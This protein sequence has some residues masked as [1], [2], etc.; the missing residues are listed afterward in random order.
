M[1]TDR[2][3]QPAATIEAGLEALAQGDW[4]EARSAFSDVVQVDESPEAL[5]GLGI[6]AWWLEDD[7]AAI[8]ARRRAYRLYQDRGDR[9]GAARVVATGLALDYH[10]RA[11]TPSSTDGS[12]VPTGCLKESNSAPSSDGSPSSKPTSPSGSTTTPPPHKCSVLGPWLS[13]DPLET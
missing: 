2:P 4:E 7:G 6:A 9:R 11:S 13:G 10:F 1:E 3:I 5:E 12:G 8:E